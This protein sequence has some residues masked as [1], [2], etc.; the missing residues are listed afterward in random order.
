MY[1]NGVNPSFGGKKILRKTRH[2]TEFSTVSDSRRVIIVLSHASSNGQRE[3]T[4][5]ASFVVKGM[6]DDEGG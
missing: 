6:W 1:G 5:V 2:G 3:G 4:W